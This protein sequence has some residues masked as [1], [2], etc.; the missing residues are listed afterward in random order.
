MRRLR[1]SRLWAATGVG[2]EV[3]AVTRQEIR[4]YVTA[5]LVRSPGV[6]NATINQHI[7]EA[8]RE[9][10][11]PFTANIVYRDVDTLATVA[12]QRLYALNA[13]VR[14]LKRLYIIGANGDEKSLTLVQERAV[15]LPFAD[16]EPTKYYLAGSTVVSGV[17]RQQVGLEPV[18]TAAYAM[19]A[20]VQEYEPIPPVLDTEG[21]VPSWVPEEWHHLIA[22]RTMELVAGVD[23]DWDVRRAW[24]E[25]FVSGFNEMM[26]KQAE[27]EFA[28]GYPAPSVGLPWTR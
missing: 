19:L 16:G 17:L 7:N 14:A 13:D 22:L 15:S 10:S 4:S 12:G 11:R 1:P 8:Y 3:G 20:L 5:R 6:D 21:S 2:A 26:W 9:V 25:E 28:V 18:P 24:R 27:S 23:E